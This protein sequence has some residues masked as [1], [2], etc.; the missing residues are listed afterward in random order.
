MGGGRVAAGR[1]GEQPGGLSQVL[2]KNTRVSGLST[3]VP[4]LICNV[5]SLCR[6]HSECDTVKQGGAM[7]GDLGWVTPA[8]RTGFGVGFKEATDAFQLGFNE[9]PA[10]H[11]EL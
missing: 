8:Q 9:A 11:S 2:P 5:V 10:A 4:G 6:S 1:W 3:G 7:C